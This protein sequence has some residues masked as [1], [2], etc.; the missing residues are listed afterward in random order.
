[1]NGGES[2]YKTLIM[3]TLLMGSP[4]WIYKCLQLEL[5]NG[6]ESYYKTYQM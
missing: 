2:Y 1:M 6:G 5:M 4:I 3:P